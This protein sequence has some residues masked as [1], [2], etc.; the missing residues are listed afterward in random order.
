M[1][2]SVKALVT[3]CQSG[4]HNGG[5][6]VV[7][8]H[9]NLINKTIRWK[10]KKIH[11]HVAAAVS[12]EVGSSRPLSDIASTLMRRNTSW[13]TVSSRLFSYMYT[14]PLKTDIVQLSCPSL[15]AFTILEVSVVQLCAKDSIYHCSLSLFSISKSATCTWP[16]SSQVRHTLKVV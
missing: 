7:A 14:M 13:W 5:L 3:H 2:E 10:K 1:T 16:T 8:M 4:V 15:K 12:P 9:S 6:W 11:F